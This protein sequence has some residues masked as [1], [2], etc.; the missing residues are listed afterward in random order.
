MAKTER[1]R[2]VTARGSDVNLSVE[3]MVRTGDT[4]AVVDCTSGGNATIQGLVKSCVHD[5]DT[6][7]VAT[8]TFPT[9]VWSGTSK[10][11][12]TATLAGLDLPAGTYYW[13]LHVGL[14]ASHATYPSLS[15]VVAYGELEVVQTTTDDPA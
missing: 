12:T 10:N 4:D 3:I 1:Q 11:T 5:A 8:F 7:A 6:E 13:A 14:D 9:T 2:I 15:G